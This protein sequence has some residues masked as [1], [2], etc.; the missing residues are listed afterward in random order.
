MD[1]AREVLRTALSVVPHAKFSFA[2][3][4]LLLAKLEL[5]RRDLPAARSVLG[6]AIAL[7]GKRSVFDYYI[8]L[9]LRLGNVDS[10]RKLH[11][12]SIELHATSSRAWSDFAAFEYEQLDEVER[13]RAIY[14]LGVGQPVLDQPDALWKAY[15]D[16]ERSVDDGGDGGRA[17]ALYERLVKR[18]ADPKVWASYALYEKSLGDE[19]AARAVFRR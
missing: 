15:V 14:E 9:E 11:Q 2:K 12:R 13:A 16:F 17:R 1:R 8:G 6:R 3:L 18:V 7:C 10:C 5:R 4:W 19:A